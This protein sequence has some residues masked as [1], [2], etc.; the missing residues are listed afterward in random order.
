MRFALAATILVPLNVVLGIVLARLTR[1]PRSFPPFTPLPIATGSVGGPLIATVGY[2]LLW[3][4]IANQTVLHS[5]FVGAGI[6]L[7]VASFSLP[8]RLSYTR[9]PRFAGVTVPAQFALGFLHTIVVGVSIAAFL[10][11]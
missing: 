11:R 4:L 6:L 8:R 2:L 3:T 9:S 7:L 1:V 5:V 10:W